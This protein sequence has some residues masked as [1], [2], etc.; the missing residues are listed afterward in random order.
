[1][2]PFPSD[3]ITLAPLSF[4]TRRSSDLYAEWPTEEKNPV[5]E[6]YSR[7]ATR[8]RAVDF[9]ARPGSVERLSAEQRAKVHGTVAG[10]ETAVEL[11]SEE[12]TSELQSRGHLVCRL[13]L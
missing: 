13:L 8:D 3:Q 7:F 10:G 1:T 11:R 9:S 2:F 5:V 4:P 6:L 12:H